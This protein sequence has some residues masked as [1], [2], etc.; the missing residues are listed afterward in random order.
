[1]NLYLTGVLVNNIVAVTAPFEQDITI[2]QAED[3]L[4]TLKLLDSSGS[5][6]DMTSGVI[7]FT[8]KKHATDSSHIISRL[9]NP[10]TGQ[11]QLSQSD[12]LAVVAGSYVYQVSYTAAGSGLQDVVV[13]LSDFTLAP[14]L[15]LPGSPVD[16]FTPSL[17]IGYGL[18]T[19]IDGYVLSNDGAA[20]L[21]EP[22]PTTLPDQTGH[23][24]QVL[25]TNGATASWETLNSLPS[26]TGHNGQFL[27]TDGT[28]PSWSAVNLSAYL[29]L[30]GGTMTGNIVLT[31]GT[32]NLLPSVASGCAI[33]SGQ[34][35]A[36]S[37]IYTDT[38]H[39]FSLQ[40]SGST[41]QIGTNVGSS[42]LLMGRTGQINQFA[43]TTQF[44]NTGIDTH[45]FAPFLIGAVNA[46]EIDIGSN[47]IGSITVASGIVSV[48]A[49]SGINLATTSLTLSFEESG[50]GSSIFQ[51]GGGDV[52][53]GGN[54]ISNAFRITALSGG[55]TSPTIGPTDLHQHTLQVTTSGV[56]ALL[57]DIRVSNVSN[58]SNVQLTSTGA[59]DV[60]S[61]TTGFAGNN[62][63]YTSYRVVSG[64]TNVTLTLTYVDQ[65]GS[66]TQ[67]IVSAATPTPVGTYCEAP[68]YINT[69]NIS[70]LKV[71][72]TASI[73][74]NV[75]VSSSV[76][77]IQ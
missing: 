75:Y 31:N 12:T 58:A 32:S 47:T 42:G 15:F 76:I 48:Q 17:V 4:I 25:G 8:V 5:V 72:A 46:T 27:E 10:S 38:L 39:T 21:W 51:F 16:T 70:S 18:P 56:L 22:T 61:I 71:T 30:A 64:T 69:T 74:N 2:A 23:S 60:I 53:L 24:G 19:L 33:G 57:T 36:F 59:T 65:T 77:G 26:Q 14:A 11:F 73:A 1:M 40:Y 49:N 54:A 37:D 9:G 52:D 29:P 45:N 20:L 68:I 66:Q 3:T 41:I 6:V 34:N 28:N 13:P 43:G 67:T 7:V 62:V 35:F 55:V 50:P 44:S 63:I